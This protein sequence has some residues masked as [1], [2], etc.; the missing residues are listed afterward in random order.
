MNILPAAA[1]AT[2]LGVAPPTE[3]LEDLDYRVP[4]MICPSRYHWCVLIEYFYRHGQ[5]VAEVMVDGKIYLGWHQGCAGQGDNCPLQWI[6]T[7]ESVL[8]ALSEEYPDAGYIFDED[9]KWED[10]W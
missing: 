6:H 5:I 8:D 3:K 10:G 1:L 2:A 9:Y 4:V 7:I